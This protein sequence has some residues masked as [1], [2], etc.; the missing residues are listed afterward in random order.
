MSKFTLVIAL[1]SYTL[2]GSGEGYGSVID[3]D[4]IFDNYGLP[5]IPARRIKGLLRESA[6]EI[7]EMNLPQKFETK[8][9]NNLFGT[10]VKEGRV[11]T[12]NLKIDDYKKR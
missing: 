9:I 8:D 1:K 7:S 10:P 12:K 2:I 6:L 5:Y 11:K 4:A 3:T